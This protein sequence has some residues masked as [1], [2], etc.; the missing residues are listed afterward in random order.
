MMSGPPPSPPPPPPPLSPPPPP[1]AWAAP[2]HRKTSGL[3]IASLVLGIVWLG[4][5]GA[6]LAV[7]FGLIALAEIKRDA[8]VEGRGLAIA[9][10][11]LGAIG[12]I[13]PIVAIVVVLA[14]G[15]VGSGDG[16]SSSADSA[17]PAR[18]STTT[19]EVTARYGTTP[20]PPAAG[21]TARQTTFGD[22]FVQCID[23]AKTYTAILRTSKGDLVVDLDAKAAPITVNNFVAL[24]R[25]KFY[26]G[27]TCHRII[28]TF[29]AQ[30]GDPTGSGAGGP[31]Y[32]FGDELPRAGAYRIGSVAMANA[33]PGTNGSQFFIITGQL[34]VSLPPQYTL[35]GQARPGQDAV[36]AALDA[37]GSSENNGVPP[38]TAVG[39]T[40]V[41]ITER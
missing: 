5:V 18:A 17:A 37:A 32:E 14:I 26:D 6:V 31:G 15:A 13:I 25:W 27:I 8:Q 7:V 40:S 28:P 9:G 34:G 30:C 35:F 33:G 2:L 21:A 36:L 4:G 23:P 38:K 16:F 11:I 24:A 12:I 19:A 20:C 39:I 41:T 1:A 29:V 3:A 10:V 22:S